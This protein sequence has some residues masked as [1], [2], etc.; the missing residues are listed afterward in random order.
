MHIVSMKLIT[1]KTHMRLFPEFYNN[2][3]TR[4]LIPISSGALMMIG[5]L[6]SHASPLVG[7]WD[8]GYGRVYIDKVFVV[9]RSD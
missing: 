2:N 6:P 4:F 8:P 1:H 5:V 9:Q 3:I 7:G